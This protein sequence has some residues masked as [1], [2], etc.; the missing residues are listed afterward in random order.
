MKSG[1]MNESQSTLF[2]YGSEQLLTQ[3]KAGKLDISRD[4]SML[5]PY[6]SFERWH[7]GNAQ[8][9]TD[10]ELQIGFRQEYEKLPENIRN[11][12]SFDDFFAQRDKMEA[13][14]RAKILRSRTTS[15][16]GY[17]RSRVDNAGF[18]RLF[19]S[20]LNHF[21]W[22]SL[23]AN[24]SGLCIAINR[25]ASGLQASAG[26]PS[27]VKPVQYGQ[28]H[29]LL[30][31]AENVIPGA[32]Q[33]AEEHKGRAEWRMVT[34]TNKI[35]QP[36]VKL[37]KNDVSEIYLSVHASSELIE[38]VKQLVALDLRYRRTRLMEVFPDATKWR[39]TARPIAV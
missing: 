13:Q 23:A 39:L 9:I 25:H 15:V 1:F 38:S 27:I 8:I 18:L 4:W 35:D 32:F 16:Q 7:N 22:Q 36:T 28:Q 19:S 26:R 3:L 33:D 29:A 10:Q 24:F 11:L 5:E 31:D 30:V 17:Q 12:L 34:P 14:V 21:G 2:Y 20:A 6:I 37:Q